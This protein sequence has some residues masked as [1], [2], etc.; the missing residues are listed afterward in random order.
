M[1]LVH[2]VPKDVPVKLV[3][4]VSMDKLVLL[5]PW[6]RQVQRDQKETKDP[7]VV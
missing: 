5:D 3:I 2:Q 1:L 6:G 7:L 4:Q